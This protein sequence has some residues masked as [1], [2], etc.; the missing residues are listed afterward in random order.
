LLV[1]EWLSKGKCDCDK[2]WENFITVYQEKVYC[3]GTE[4]DWHAESFGFWMNK[5]N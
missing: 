3:I 1:F 4:E 2:F 5:W